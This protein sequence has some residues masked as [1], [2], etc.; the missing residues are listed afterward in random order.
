MSKMPIVII[1]AGA[2]SLV[3]AAELASAGISVV[4]YEQNKAAARKFLVAGHGGF[5]LTH[6]EDVDIFVSRYDRS[7]I[8]E[9][10]KAFDNKALVGWL[11]NL[12][13]PTYIGSSGK[14]FPKQG[15]KPVQVLKAILTYLDNHGVQ[16]FYEHRMVDFDQQYVEL[17]NGANHL[18][19]EYAKLLLGLGG[20]SWRKTGSDGRWVELFESKGIRVNSLQAANSGLTTS[21]SYSKLAGQVLKNIQ[22]QFLDH[23]KIGEVVFT[24]YGIE[25]APVYYMNRFIR[26]LPFPVILFLDLKPMF[27]EESIRKFLSEPNVKIIDVLRHKIKISPVAVELI[28]GLTKEIYTSAELLA[29]MV[30]KFPVQV[31]GFRDIDEVI[32]TAGGVCFTELDSELRLHKFP[33]VFCIGEM[34][35]WEA[36]TGGYL[37]QACF[38]SGHWVASRM[39]EAILQASLENG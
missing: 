12:G 21:D 29:G 18:R 1:G 3:A 14:V 7:E 9:I 26:K 37:L 32:S 39:K 25:G 4:I 23:Q 27:T 34:L 38:S 15:M 24:S 16:I 31:N 17:I 35:D 5:N 33:H 36:P 19:V 11:K 20:G 10:V 22:L 28:K 13:V 8:R 30:K 6:S 2:A